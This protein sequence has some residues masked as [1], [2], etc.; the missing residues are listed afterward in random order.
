MHSL[1]GSNNQW[2]GEGTSQTSGSA[3]NNWSPQTGCCCKPVEALA[4]VA[5][6]GLS[7]HVLAC[8]SCE[9][10]SDGNVPPVHYTERGKLW[11]CTSGYQR[12]HT[13]PPP[14]WM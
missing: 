2:G 9:T 6:T 5:S 14:G 3:A 10:L 1:S 12:Q 4:G 13:A 7:C 8:Q 11:S